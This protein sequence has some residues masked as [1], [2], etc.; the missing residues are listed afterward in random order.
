MA[1]RTTQTVSTKKQRKLVI[2]WMIKQVKECGTDKE[3]LI[4]EI[5]NLNQFSRS[6]TV[7]LELHAF[8]KKIAGGM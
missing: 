5:Q 2:E 8:R 3:I 4:R 7:D 1:T 6:Q